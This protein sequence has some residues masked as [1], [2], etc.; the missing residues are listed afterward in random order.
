MQ[1]ITI[2]D[3]RKIKCAC[4]NQSLSINTKIPGWQ[5]ENTETKFQ[6]HSVNADPAFKIATKNT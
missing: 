1:Q 4:M 6:F 5:K 2:S 3:E